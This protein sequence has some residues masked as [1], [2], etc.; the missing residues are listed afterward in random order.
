MKAEIL[1][2]FIEHLERYEAHMRIDE[3]AVITERESLLEHTRRTAWYFERIWEEKE[4]ADMVLCF[5]TQT[6][7][8]IGRAHV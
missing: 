2:D 3:N 5:Q 8:K 6:Y 7:G 1:E 4:V